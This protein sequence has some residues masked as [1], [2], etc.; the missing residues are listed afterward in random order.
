MII[1][2]KRLLL[3]ILLATSAIGAHAADY[4]DVWYT[5]SEN[6][7][8]VNLVQSESFIFATF[9]IYGQ[10]GSPTWYTAQLTWDGT[11]MFS[12]GLYATTGT[13]FAAPWQNGTG[14]VV[15]AGTASFEPSSL[16]AY[17]G[18][19]TYTVS[20]VGT[21]T[22]TIERFTLTPIVLGGTYTGGQSGTY[23]ACAN[24][25]DNRAYIDHY[26][27]EVTHLGSGSATFQ[28]K[29]A[30][31]L[32]CTLSGTLE[33]HGQ[34]YRIP[35]ATYQCSDGVNTLAILHEL[36]A[37]AQGIEGRMS[38]GSAAGACREDTRFSAVLQ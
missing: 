31:G 14:P 1:M 35:S 6:G 2:F 19:L 13:W 22:K 10:N 32:T 34:Q 30:A 15:Q 28:F 29:Y 26:D 8:G 25:A 33:Q 18:T 7:W 17:R 21:V 27:L 36:K 12:G 24:V 11:S 9:Y 3:A 16:N 5:P 23:S 37:T 20:G 38:A 4:T